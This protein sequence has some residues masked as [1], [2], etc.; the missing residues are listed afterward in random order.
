MRYM[1]CFHTS[2]QIM[3][4]ATDHRSEF[5]LSGHTATQLKLLHKLSSSLPACSTSSWSP[6]LYVEGPHRIWI[7]KTAVYYFSLRLS[8]NDS[9]QLANNSEGTLCFV[10]I[11]SHVPVCELHSCGAM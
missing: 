8:A 9:R 3:S 5:I 6:L 7:N 4:A 10:C 11:Y 1:S 2:L